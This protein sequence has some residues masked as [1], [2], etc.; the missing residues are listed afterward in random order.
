MPEMGNTQVS[1]RD[2]QGIAAVVAQHVRID[3]ERHLGPISDPA[4]QRMKRLRRH[5]PI[6]MDAS[7]YRKLNVL[8]EFQP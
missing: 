3:R 2:C 8:D 6:T 7:M 4:E 1:G 5:R